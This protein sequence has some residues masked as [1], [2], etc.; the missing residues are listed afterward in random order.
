MKLCKLTTSN[1]HKQYARSPNYKKRET[2]SS[3]TFFSSSQHTHPSNQHATRNKLPTLK[4]NPTASKIHSSAS[5]SILK[6]TYSIMPY[7]P[8]HASKKK[9]DGLAIMGTGTMAPSGFRE[10]MTDK[11]CSFFGKSPTGSNFDPSSSSCGDRD[12]NEHSRKEHGSFSHHHRSSSH[13]HGGSSHHRGPSTY[14]SSSRSTYGQRSLTSHAYPS[15]A[16]MPYEGSLRPSMGTTVMNDYS[17]GPPR[18]Y[19]PTTTLRPS[20]YGPSS[21]LSRY[22]SQMATARGPKR[23]VEYE[24]EY[25]MKVK[26]SER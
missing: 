2:F 7:Q 3:Y 25:T 14:Q 15:M 8:S 9:T 12:R 20:A 13:H 21:A 16:I 23:A 22:P 26:Y 5:S 11:V 19:Q 18:F 4:T 6:D 24:V 1:V 17:A 10:K